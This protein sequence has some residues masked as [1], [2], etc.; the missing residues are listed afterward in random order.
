MDGMERLG[1]VFKNLRDARNMVKQRTL[2]HRKT[3]C[4]IGI[5]TTGLKSIASPAKAITRSCLPD[6]AAW[7]ATKLALRQMTNCSMTA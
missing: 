1:A 3:L 4:E 7:S 2:I 5:V 6:R